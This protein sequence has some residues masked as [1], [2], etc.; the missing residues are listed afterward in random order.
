MRA[1]PAAAAAFALSCLLATPAGAAPRCKLLVD[2]AGD[3][4]VQD[5]VVDGFGADVDVVSADVATSRT[6]LTAVV[7][8]RGMRSSDPAQD[9]QG[10]QYHFYFSVSAL[11]NFSLQGRPG[12]G[13]ALYGHAEGWTSGDEERHDSQ[14]SETRFTAATITVAGNEVRLTVPLAV[15]RRYAGPLAEGT[16]L[17]DFAA[18]TSRSVGDYPGGPVPSEIPTPAGDAEPVVHPGN[19]WDVADGQRN[20]VYRVGERSCVKAG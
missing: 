15:L 16:K 20:A 3:T 14:Y 12:V 5:T 19:A 1:R 8:V 6:H 7:R 17:Y 10:R 11:K 18:Y 4:G 2:P 9:Q 13:A